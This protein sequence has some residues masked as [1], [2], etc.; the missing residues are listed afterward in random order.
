MRVAA[1]TAFCCCVLLN[2]G[3]A[4][5]ED[6]LTMHHLSMQH[7]SNSLLFIKQKPGFFTSSINYSGTISSDFER[8]P[9]DIYVLQFYSLVQ[10]NLHAVLF[11]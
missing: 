9:K 6:H 3:K 2:S 11:R 1:N 4:K 7:L 8:S 10:L 5:K